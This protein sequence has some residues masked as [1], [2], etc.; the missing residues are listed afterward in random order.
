MTLR[1][2]P[3]EFISQGGYTIPKDPE[4]HRLAVLFVDQNFVDKPNLTDYAKVWLAVSVDEKEQPLAV[5]GMLGFQ[6]R[7]DIFVRFL[8]PQSL[9][10]LYHR[11]NDFFSDNGLRGNEVLVYVNPDERPEQKCPDVAG[12]LAAVGAQPANRYAI[13]VK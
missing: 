9:S 13:R 10:K 3:L 12:S 11:A 6:M 2:I 1:A 4:L 7:P 5:R 8:D